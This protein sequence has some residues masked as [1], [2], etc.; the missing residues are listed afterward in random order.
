MMVGQQVQA[1]FTV[2][3]YITSGENKGWLHSAVT[4]W[5]AGAVLKQNSSSPGKTQ[6]K[7]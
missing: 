3:N 2:F 4:L 6:L 1:Q 7:K 5:A